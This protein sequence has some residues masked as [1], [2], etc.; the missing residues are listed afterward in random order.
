MKSRSVFAHTIRRTTLALERLEERETPAG[1]VTLSLLNNTFTFTGDNDPGGNE[2][3]VTALALDRFRIDGLNGTTFNVAGIGNIGATFDTGAPPPGIAPIALPNNGTT[4]IKA[5]F[6]GNA[7]RFE[8]DGTG[9]N[10]IP[11]GPPFFFNLLPP[12]G[13][14]DV[15]LNMGAGND[16]VILRQF[17]AKSVTI[18]STAPVGANTDNDTVTVLA[19][20][21]FDFDLDLTPETYLGGM[22][23]NLTV[24][25]QTGNDTINIAARVAGNVV[26]TLKDANDSFT[27]RGESRIGGAVTV[28]ETPTAVLG[29]N[30]FS[31]AE[32]T[33]IGKGVTLT[34]TNNGVAATVVNSTIGGDLKLTSGSGLLG[35]TFD[36]TNL[37]V[38]GALTV[39]GGTLQDI[40]NGQNLTIG[41]N[42]TLTMG[43]GGNGAGDNFSNATI[44]GG[45]TATYGTG[46]DVLTVQN[47]TVAGNLVV[48]GGE[49]QDRF[50][51]LN[52]GVGKA[53]TMTMGN[54]GNGA[55][56]TLVN[57]QVSGAVTINYGA[58]AGDDTLS[59]QGS[60]FATSATI[61][62]GAGLDRFTM[63]NTIVGLNFAYTGGAGGNGGNP[64]PDLISGVTVGGTFKVTYGAG[65]E[66]LQFNNNRVTLAATFVGG[67][68]N[69][70]FDIADSSF[71]AALAVTGGIGTDTINASNLTVVT[72]TM[73]T[74][75]G[76][77][78]FVNISQSGRYHGKV[79]INTGGTGTDFDN[80]TIQAT[81]G[82]EVA[83]LGGLTIITGPMP[84]NIPLDR[85]EI[86]TQPGRVL[87]L[88]GFTYADAVAAVDDV[89]LGNNLLIL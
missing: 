43:N 76:G 56:D 40:V 89:I 26:A 36:L 61:N 32:N 16:T 68:G 41:K 46:N 51:G 66:E 79:T 73:L 63:Q 45:L 19:G 53:L 52:L 74:T 15:T 60:T 31:I 35:S 38:A 42:V 84:D 69:D 2:V 6:L 47:S 59:I 57:T 77:N 80:I 50:T 85:T 18:N 48:T 28:T 70:R 8:F 39:V 12:V 30:T 22:R 1:V 17:V 55:G 49:G 37:T 67:N 23:G 3:K 82:N 10:P 88:N 65:N 25:G 33:L 29:S 87:V 78:D 72:T 24:N 54:G 5:T 86:G 11:S 75:S 81:A 20:G 14:G 34:N 27:I 4:G 44:A 64:L 7:D 21:L 9:V 58:T 83:F 13:F 62:A 71:L